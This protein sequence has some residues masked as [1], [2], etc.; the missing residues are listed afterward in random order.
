[1]LIYSCKAMVS[2]VIMIVIT[3]SADAIAKFGGEW[4]GDDPSE[5]GKAI[6]L[7][8]DLQLFH[9]GFN[10]Q[11]ASLMIFLAVPSSWGFAANAIARMHRNGQENTTRAIYLVN[12]GHSGDLNKFKLLDQFRLI[13]H[14][15]LNM[16]VGDVAAVRRDLTRGL[17]V[18]T[19]LDIEDWQAAIEID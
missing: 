10:L 5:E 6:V 8:I 9:K 17:K 11:V 12:A 4:N 14:W 16:T 15:S 3:C 7:V 1:M 18:D 2:T 19:G 13:T